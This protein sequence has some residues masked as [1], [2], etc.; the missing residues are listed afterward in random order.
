MAIPLVAA[1]ACGLAT[2]TATTGTTGTSS[3]YE[4]VARGTV[5]EAKSWLSADLT[6][7][8]RADGASLLA[9]G[10]F[11]SSGLSNTARGEQG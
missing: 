6:S 3:R 5:Y 7:R 2:P 8:L 4:A 10:A 9:G 1:L 11:R